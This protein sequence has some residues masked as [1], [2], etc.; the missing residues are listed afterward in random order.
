MIH[1]TFSSLLALAF[2]VLL[3]TPLTAQIEPTFRDIDYVGDGLQNHLLDVYIPPNTGSPRPAVVYIHGGGW[4]NRT[5]KGTLRNDLRRLYEDAQYVIV[6]INHRYSTEAIWPAQIHDCKTAIRHIRHHADLYQIDPCAIGVMGHSSGGHLAAMLGAAMGIDSLE[7]YHLGYPNESS[8]VQAV[9]DF[10]GPT[11]FLQV[12]NMYPSTCD[13]PVIY[14]EPGSMVSQLMGCLVTECADKVQSANPINYIDGNEP[15]FSIYHGTA[16]CTVPFFQSG[17]LYNAL[18]E[19]NILVQ[20]N[21]PQEAVHADPIFYSW[22]TILNLTNFFVQHLSAATCDEALSCEFADDHIELELYAYMEGPFDT[23][24]RQMVTHLNTIRGLLPGQTP[25]NPASPP[26][27]SGQ[28]YNKPPWNYMGTEGLNWTDDDYIGT[29]T[30]WVLVSFRNGA[31]KDTEVVQTAALVHQDGRITFPNPCVLT[32]TMGTEFYVV[33]DHRN[34]MNIMTPTAI[35]VVNNQLTYDFRASD[36]YITGLGFGQ[37]QL[38][39]GE[40]VMFAADAD[41]SD[42]PS[43]IVDGLDK[44]IWLE[45]N[46]TFDDY[47]PPDFNLDGDVNGEDKSLWFDNHGVY[48]RVPK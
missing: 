23:L 29:E 4:K 35:S 32:E 38:P 11:D 30:D 42:I 47:C 37:K 18:I 9:I 10:F 48:S 5:K 15:P 24:T 14:E 25:A 31:T 12:D 22:N 7:G 46:G 6:D 16:D 17:I 45:G 8:D 27:P 41:Q 44:S 34:H 20:V 26:T 40:W 1:P 13:S 21:F 2:Y 43:S 33:I 39:T 28:P 3:T 36:S 19:N